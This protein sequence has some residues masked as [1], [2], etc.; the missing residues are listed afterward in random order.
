MINNPISELPDNDEDYVNSKDTS[1]IVDDNYNYYGNVDCDSLFEK[2]VL[3]YVLT[4]GK[5]IQKTSSDDN[6]SAEIVTSSSTSLE[7]KSLSKNLFHSNFNLYSDIS[8]IHVFF[9]LIV[10]SDNED[11]GFRID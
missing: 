4:E 7:R 11:I 9:A 1:F 3:Y 6:S 2:Q 10:D 5:N 8:K